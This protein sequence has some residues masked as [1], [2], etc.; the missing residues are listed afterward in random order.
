MLSRQLRWE[1]DPVVIDIGP[2]AVRWYSLA[3]LLAFGVGFLLVRGAYRREGR[4]E[5]DLESLLLSMVLGAVVGARLGHCLFYRPAYYLEH[6]LEVVAVWKGIRGLASHGGAIGILV[7]LFLHSRRHP[8][9]P[10]LWLLDRIAGPTALGGM[11]IRVGNFMNSEILGRPSE[12][13]WA[14]VFGRVDGLPRHPA[15]LYEAAAYGLVAALLLRLEWRRGASPP[16]GVPAGLFLLTVFGAR[17]LIEGLKE[18]HAAWA[19]D[20]PLSVG[21]MLSFPFVLTGLWLVARPLASSRV[22]PLG[23]GSIGGGPLSPGSER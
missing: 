4:D 9:Q 14:V 6:P 19:L 7:A 5:A 13:P 22:P 10:F 2:L 17:I 8:D 20:L 1:I 21:Q 3:W 16:R 18:R 12:V 15:Q 11:L 23:S